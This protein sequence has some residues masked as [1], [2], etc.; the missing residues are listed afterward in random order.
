LNLNTKVRAFIDNH[1]T[2]ARLWDIESLN[3]VF[4]HDGVNLPVGNCRKITG[5]NCTEQ[6]EIET[7]TAEIAVMKWQAGL[8]FAVTPLH[9]RE[10]LRRVAQCISLVGSRPKKQ[11]APHPQLRRDPNIYF[12]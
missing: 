4:G 1:A 8:G 7:W 5:M 6:K 3:L 12:R 2:L 11:C 10:V 9:G